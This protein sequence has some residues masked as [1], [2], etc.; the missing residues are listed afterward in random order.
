[1]NRLVEENEGKACEIRISYSLN[2]KFSI[3]W[4]SVDAALVVS[5][6]GA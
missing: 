5:T 3:L 1:M 4:C 6:N 2:Q